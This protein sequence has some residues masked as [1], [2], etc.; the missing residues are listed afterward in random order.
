MIKLSKKGISAVVTYPW[1]YC[2]L[3]WRD[4]TYDIEWKNLIKLLDACFGRTAVGH[5]FGGERGRRVEV[6]GANFPTT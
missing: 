1:M 6:K 2:P 3:L 5:F 4:Y